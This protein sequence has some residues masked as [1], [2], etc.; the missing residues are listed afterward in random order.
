LY[1]AAVALTFGEDCEIYFAGG[2]LPMLYRAGLTI[3]SHMA[4]YGVLVLIDPT[5][6]SVAVAATADSAAAA[7]QGAENIA[8]TIWDIGHDL[9]MDAQSAREADELAKRIDQVLA[10]IRKKYGRHWDVAET[11]LRAVTGRRIPSAVEFAER[12]NDRNGKRLLESFEAAYKNLVEFEDSGERQACEEALSAWL[13]VLATHEL[14]IATLD[15]RLTTDIAQTVAALEKA[16]LTRPELQVE[17]ERALAV[18]RDA[19]ALRVL[20]VPRK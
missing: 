7:S 20:K 11:Q 17:I 3:A 16:S 18:C 14:T 1:P 5:F 13:G 6:V 10:P 19:E 9:V 12:L 8:S 2:G 4:K 15:L